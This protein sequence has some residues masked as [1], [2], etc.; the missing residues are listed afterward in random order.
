[1]NST[2]N[3]Q[4]L[5]FGRKK[6]SKKYV[7]GNFLKPGSSILPKHLIL[8]I[9]MTYLAS[10]IITFEIHWI[11]GLIIAIICPFGMCT[12]SSNRVPETVVSIEDR[13]ENKT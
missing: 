12:L 4:L 11:I 8:F 5:S 13:A 1:M 3:S 6:S 9:L 10:I 2:S 7:W